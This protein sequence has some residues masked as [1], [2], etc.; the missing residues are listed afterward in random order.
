LGN[1]RTRR[2]R[3]SRRR[4]RTRSRR[5]RRSKEEKEEEATLIKSRGRHLQVGKS[6]FF[7]IFQNF[8]HRFQGSDASALGSCSMD[9]SIALVA[10][11][12]LL[13]PS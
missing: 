12:R 11:G 1:W 4:S 8:H 13:A 10:L 9:G 2:R 6:I 3:I 7:N 5:R